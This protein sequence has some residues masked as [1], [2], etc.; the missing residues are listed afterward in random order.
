MNR[1]LFCFVALAALAAAP[2]ESKEPFHKLSPEQRLQR[3]EKLAGAGGKPFV[4]VTRADLTGALVE[5]GAV[6]AADV[7]EIVSPVN[8]TIKWVIDDGSPVKKGQR[9]L[10]LDD[11]AIR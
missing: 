7:S 2:P 8:T 1:S 9:L 10:E 4:P 3:V 11:S 5:R 6:E